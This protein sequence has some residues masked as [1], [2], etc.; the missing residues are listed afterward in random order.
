MVSLA[1][2]VF[3]LGITNIIS[4]FFVLLSCRCMLGTFVNKLWKYEWYKKFYSLHCYFWWIF[5]I[6]VIFHAVLAIITF[7]NPFLK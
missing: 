4:L 6:S 5:I 1:Q 2:I 7:G 3:I